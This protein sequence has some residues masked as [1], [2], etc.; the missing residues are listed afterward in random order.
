MKLIPVQ[1]REQI[2]NQKWDADREAG[3]SYQESV[4]EKQVEG[5]L[6]GW[7]E[8][9]AVFEMPCMVEVAM[10]TGTAEFV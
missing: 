6:R 7:Q 2:R 1:T 3:E 8:I 4:V 9:A 5:L 10:H